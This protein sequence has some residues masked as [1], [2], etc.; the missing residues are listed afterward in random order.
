MSE[1]VLSTVQRVL[2]EGLA[3]KSVPPG[4]DSEGSQAGQSMFRSLIDLSDADYVSTESIIGLGDSDS[5]VTPKCSCAQWDIDVTKINHLTQYVT[6]TSV[7][8]L[9]T[10]ILAI[11]HILSR[12]LISQVPFPDHNL[13][14]FQLEGN[15]FAGN[16]PI[17]DLNPD[18]DDFVSLH[19]APDVGETSFQLDQMLS[20]LV[21]LAPHGAGAYHPQSEMPEPGSAGRLDT[22]LHQS[23]AWTMAG[24]T[25]TESVS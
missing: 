23:V 10:S 9:E 11:G 6:Q 25:S 7:A 8:D 18:L 24:P 19:V 16:N 5:Q 17:A 13:D 21:D 4:A 22:S 3:K 1:I 2:Q 20:H 12:Q 15:F 14:G